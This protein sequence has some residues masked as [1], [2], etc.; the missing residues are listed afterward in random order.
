MKAVLRADLSLSSQN[1]RSCP[2]MILLIDNY[3]SFVHNLARYLRRLGQQTTVVR[4]DGITVHEIKELRPDAIVLSPGPCAPQQAGCCLEVIR[5]LHSTI[6]MLGVCLGHQAISEAFGGSTIRS[7]EPV[8]GR[9]SSLE[10]DGTGS[11]TGLPNSFAVGRYHSLVACPES[12][13]PCLRVNARLADGTIMAIE[14]REFP[15][16]GWQFHPESVLTEFG[17]QMLQAF[18]AQA[19]IASEHKAVH[20]SSE[21][22]C[23]SPVQPDWFTRAIEFPEA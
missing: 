1:K 16:V 19:K 2:I 9:A 3:D 12:L 4:N 11:F 13:P 20:T 5:D 6:P 7:N 17:Y 15:V 18:L 10:H 8:H 21:L 14:H 23:A 22:R